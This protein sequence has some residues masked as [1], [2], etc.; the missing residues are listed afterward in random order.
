VTARLRPSAVGLALA[1]TAMC[2]VATAPAVRAQSVSQYAFGFPSGGTAL[3][4]TDVGVQ[5]S[6][7]LTVSFH[8]DPEAGCAAYGLCEYSGTITV[9][10]RSG[11]L[12]VQRLRPHHRIAYF[13]ALALAP[14]QWAYMGAA[15]VDR[16]TPGQQG[17][18]CA[19]AQTGQLG[20]LSQASVHGS[21]LTIAVLVRGGSL[22]TTRCAGPLDG[23]LAGVSPRATISARAALHGRTTLD[24]SGTR[25]YAAHGFAGTITSTL[26]LRLGNPTRSASSAPAFPP[27]LKTQ[28]VR[29]VTEHLDLTRVAGGVTAAVQ[30]TADPI[31]CRLLD[32]CGMSGTLS[33]A[34]VKRGA[35]AEVLAMGP[36]SRPYGDFLAALG[37]NPSGR[38]RGITVL[39]T[40]SLDG[41][42]SAGLNQSGG[43]CTDTAPTGELAL[44]LGGVGHRLIG[45]AVSAGSW[46]TRCPGPMFSNGSPLLSASLPQSSLGRRQFT[47]DVRGT[48]SLEDDGYA[49]TVHGRLSLDLRRARITQ[50]VITEPT[51]S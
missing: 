16:S 49:A 48:G 24:L 19:D 38:S 51:G 17:G 50:Q 41:Y 8:G 33:L 44:L 4:T 12:L 10:P 45:R 32:T 47:I 3:S 27:G 26:V 20:S 46:R 36:A 25:T 28:R 31:V 35:T 11:D 5:V 9:H 13:A 37:L 15:Q 30:G 29:T 43:S 22:L 1:V 23:D 21:S 42:V 18:T 6:G 39:L 14:G 2:L 40:V 7:E 34:P